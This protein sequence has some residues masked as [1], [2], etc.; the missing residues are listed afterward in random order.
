LL[1]L[2]L[3]RV[4]AEE[5]LCLAGVLAGDPPRKNRRVSLFLHQLLMQLLLS[6]A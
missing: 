2:Y 5:F 4:P 3:L 6:N 1:G